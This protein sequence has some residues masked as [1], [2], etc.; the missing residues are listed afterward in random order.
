[1]VGRLLSGQELIRGCQWVVSPAMQT[2]I[3]IICITFTFGVLLLGFRRRMV[4]D[5]TNA[6]NYNSAGVLLLAGVLF[7]FQ[8]I[9]CVQGWPS[10]LEDLYTV[11]STGIQNGGAAGFAG[12]VLVIICA[13][14]VLM[15]LYDFCGDIHRYMEERLY[16][17]F[18]KR[19]NR[20]VWRLSHNA[21]HL[22]SIHHQ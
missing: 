15:A 3:L 21:G 1:M 10:A 9:D 5:I 19:Q 11:Y 14:L 22:R 17:A 13:G 6:T 18:W 8:A 7:G 12:G 2:S 16:R 20:R 4:G